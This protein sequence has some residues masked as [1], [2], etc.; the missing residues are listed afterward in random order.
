MGK[1]KIGKLRKPPGS[2]FLR[3]VK[4]LIVVALVLALAWWGKF[5]YYAPGTPQVAASTP[6]PKPE[7]AEEELLV[8]EPLTVYFKYRSYYLHKTQMAN[9]REFLSGA[10]SFKGLEFHVDAYASGRG[11]ESYNMGLSKRR[12]R[13]VRNYLRANGVP[14]SSIITRAHGESDPVANNWTDSGRGRNRRATIT[15]VIPK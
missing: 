11:S 14:G 9:I 8:G 3:L 5:F 1:R 12:A 4:A 15:M 13:S 6:A 10:G 7:Q 2:K